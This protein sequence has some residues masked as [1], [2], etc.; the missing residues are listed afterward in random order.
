MQKN[1]LKAVLVLASMLINFSAQ[2]DSAS[3]W[4]AYNKGNYQQAF[5]DCVGLAEGGDASCQ[6]LLGNL[7]KYGQNVPQ[8]TTLSLKWLNSSVAAGNPTG[9]EIL[10][11]TLLNGR[12]GVDKNIP[13]AYELFMLSSAKGNTWADNQL[14]NMHRFGIHVTKNLTEALRYFQK[15]ADKGNPAAQANLA[16]VYRLGDGVAKNPD[17]AFQLALKSSEQ[18]WAG[19]LNI[20]GV[21][22]RDG[23]GVRQD[24]E[25]AISLFK[26]AIAVNKNL[27]YS[28]SNIGR[29]YL[30]GTGIPVNRNEARKWFEE[31]A[32][33]NDGDSFAYLSDIHVSQ[34]KDSPTD[35]AKAF[36][37]ANKAAALNR[38]G[39]YNMLGYVYREGIGHPVDYEKAITNFKKG[40]ELGNA[41]SMLH[42]AVMY[43]KGMGVPK[44]SPEALALFQRAASNPQLSERNKK[45]AEDYLA[46]VAPKP[47]VAQS[48]TTGA[49][50]VNETKINSAN[51]PVVQ[52]SS[53]SASDDKLKAE[54]LDR[55]EKMQQQLTALQASS[56][57]ATMNTAVTNQ[58][59]VFANRKALVI[60]NDKYKN[61]S[62][63]NNATSDAKAIAVTLNGLGYK[64]TTHL[65][66]DEKGFKQALRDFKMAIQGGDEVLVFFA[67]HG[68][69]LGS[70]NY[71]LPIDIKGDNEEQVKDEAIQ[72]QRILDDLQERKAK[73]TL[74]IIDA[75]RDNPFKGSGR[76]LGGRG[77]APT[78]AATGQ[79]VMFSAGSGQQALDKL[80][81]NDK[82]KNGLF[83][84]ILL[85][86]MNKPG[87]SVDRLLRNVRNEV[88]TL[89][90]SVGHEQTPALYDQAVG[91]FYFKQ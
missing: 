10:G 76:A 83:T 25:K 71:L 38:P 6:A 40:I 7:Y 3:A 75:C 46:Q 62:E 84:R 64:V 16:D 57:T 69:Q 28:Y 39:G 72:L 65:D 78:T 5:A 68:V 82:E 50:K 35:Q 73:F 11:D 1:L 51:T 21:L 41:N 15:A 24:S 56:N 9:Q 58:K 18:K 20:L 90:K 26:E 8:N 2:A 74:A 81:Q 52:T 32:K 30:N 36:D 55:L 85:K 59:I 34:S 14:G 91:E 45:L 49:G 53:A 12:N 29:M 86:E 27:T 60:G 80:G 88:V 54:L 79:M 70:T 66:I 42:L 13:K 23:V 19:G 17:L 63:L 67:G 61:V 44:N 37:Y 4:A 48:T 22:F 87:V 89:A 77:L 47:I 33:V 31:G 43:E